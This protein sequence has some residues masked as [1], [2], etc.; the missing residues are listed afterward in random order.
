ME[1]KRSVATC[2]WASSTLL[3]GY[4]VWLEAW[5]SLW[6]CARDI[7]PRHL[8]DPDVCQSCSR[9]DPRP[10]AA[11]TPSPASSSDHRRMNR[12]S[13]ERDN[14]GSRQTADR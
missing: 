8:A 4:P 3:F 13:A 12:A 7:E 1:T 5:K 9:W 2:R 6:T 10:E 11:S 14:A